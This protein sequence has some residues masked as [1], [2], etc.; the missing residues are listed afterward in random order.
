MAKLP[1]TYTLCPEEPAP[2][3]FTAMTPQTLFALR[4]GVVDMTI[5]QAQLVWPP[6]KKGSTTINNHKKKS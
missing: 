5:N 4:Y 6:A 2:K 1:Y 3:Q